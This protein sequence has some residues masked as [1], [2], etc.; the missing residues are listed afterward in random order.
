MEKHRNR[1]SVCV[2]KF[3]AQIKCTSH[4]SR[5]VAISATSHACALAVID[6]LIEISRLDIYP[7]YSVDLN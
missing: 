2:N 1:S 7:C 3:F 4:V 5:C 6:N